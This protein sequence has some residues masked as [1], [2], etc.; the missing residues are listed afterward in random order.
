MG[1]TSKDGSAIRFGQ[2]H[3]LLIEPRKVCLAV[4]PDTGYETKYFFREKYL[5][6]QKL[7]HTLQASSLTKSHRKRRM[8]LCLLPFLALRNAV[9]VLEPAE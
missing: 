5:W 8:V 7:T 3:N 9:S 2:T 4:T 1:R 6:F